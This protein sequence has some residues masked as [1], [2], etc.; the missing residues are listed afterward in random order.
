MSILR[1]DR[2][3][4]ID[5]DTGDVI[6]SSSNAVLRSIDQLGGCIP[7]LLVIA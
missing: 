4:S 5:V 6:Y 2:L 1:V 7:K 3:G